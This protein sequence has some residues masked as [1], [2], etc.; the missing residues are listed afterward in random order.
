M[1]QRIRE[2]DPS[3]RPRERLLERGPAA[4]SDAE[5]IAVLLRTGRPGSGAV[6]SAHELL[7]E[8]GGL[9]GVARLEMAE[10]MTRPGV[11]PAKAAA[12][13]AALELGD[14]LA[15]SRVK[16]G[17]RLDQPAV[18]ADYLT[19]RLQRERREVFGF[20]S[21]DS[22][23]RLLRCR[24]LTLGTRTQ[25]PVDPAALL[26]QALVDDAAGLLLYHNHPSGDLAPS[27]DDCALTRR[28]VQG[29]ELV[30]LRVLDHLLLSEGRWL[31][32]RQMRP[33]LFT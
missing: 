13:L 4:L 24:E 21:L 30:G 15:R 25:A 3:Q 16:R 14:R 12:L 27:R 1:V 29:A 26:R 20:L 32:L 19:R 22:R 18:A 2:M 33:E 5:L 31:S 7:A 9:G 10:L 6:T 11:G 28:L 8:A 23:H 17:A